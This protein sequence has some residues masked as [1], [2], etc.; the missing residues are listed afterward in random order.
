[1][2][3]RLSYTCPY[4]R[5]QTITRVNTCGFSPNLVCALILWKSGLGLL[6]GKFILFLTVIFP[7][8]DRVGDVGLG[9]GRGEEKG[10]IV[11]HY[12]KYQFL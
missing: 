4:F 7:P 2:S 10:F 6:M 12:Y 9:M 5:F 3:V 11:S 1:M 8:Q